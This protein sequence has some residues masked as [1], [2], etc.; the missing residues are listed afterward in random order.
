M[1]ASIFGRGKHPMTDPRGEFNLA[2]G[3]FEF[4]GE[5]MSEYQP[6]T[7]ERL[8]EIL[9]AQ[10][11]NPRSWQQEAADALAGQPQS[12]SGPEI[13]EAS[14]DLNGHQMMT[15]QAS[16]K[17]LAQLFSDYDN[18]RRM[19][20]NLAMPWFEQEL[21]KLRASALSPSLHRQ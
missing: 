17:A 11:Q 2:N 10:D 18:E 5:E 20:W 6:R 8:I 7:R 16:V 13:L 9:R 19:G 1:E 4:E 14:E 15:V 3:R 21:A 12:P